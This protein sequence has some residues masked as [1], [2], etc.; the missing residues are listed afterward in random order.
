MT[1][2]E[3]NAEKKNNQ[4]KSRNTQQKRPKKKNTIYIKKVRQQ[5]NT[6]SRADDVDRMASIQ[7]W[8]E[9]CAN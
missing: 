9:V 2:F 8:F 5:N 1:N 4:I 3:E 7:M 6:I